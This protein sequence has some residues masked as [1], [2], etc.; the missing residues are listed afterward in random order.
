MVLVGLSCALAKSMF[1]G[2]NVNSVDCEAREQF[3][4]ASPAAATRKFSFRRR[5]DCVRTRAA[6]APTFPR[7]ET[8]FVCLLLNN[9]L[10]KCDRDGI[11]HANRTCHNRASDRSKTAGE[12]LW[13]NPRSDLELRAGHSSTT[14]MPIPDQTWKCTYVGLSFQTPKSACVNDSVGTLG[15]SLI[16]HPYYVSPWDE[17]CSSNNGASKPLSIAGNICSIR[18]VLF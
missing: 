4:L 8:T 17:L 2:L 6:A 1:V 9:P 3:G 12:M 5:A 10:W 7:F 13:R 14:C 15:A 11:E 16:D 18:I